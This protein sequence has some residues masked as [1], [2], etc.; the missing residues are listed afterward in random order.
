MIESPSQ[1]DII[2]NENLTA[3]LHQAVSKL[4]Q[5]IGTYSLYRKEG[6][7]VSEYDDDQNVV[8][9]EYMQKLVY[10]NFYQVRETLSEALQCED[11]EEEGILELS[12]LIEAIMTTNEEL[13]T[14]ILDYM[15]FYVYVRSKNYEK[16]QYKNLIDLLDTLIE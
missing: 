1:T 9:E 13:E 2:F 8:A 16:L 11:Y 3:E 15:L 4:Q 7:S 6:S 5:L 10:E 12:Q 14:S